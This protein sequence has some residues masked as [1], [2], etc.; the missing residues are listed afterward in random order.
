MTSAP[1]VAVIGGTGGIGS[2][3]VRRLLADGADVLA[4]G[5]DAGRLAELAALGAAVTTLDLA[6]PQAPGALAAAVAERFGGT[7]DALVAASGGH[8]PTGPTRSLDPAAVRRSLEENLLGVLGCV[9]AL[10]PALDRAATP[11]V[12]LLSGGG[13]TGPRPGYTAYALAKV[14]LVR[15]AENLA[16]EEPGW[17]VNAVAPGYVAT[18]IH[19]GTGE[20]AP[21]S[22]VEADVPAALIA[23]LIGPGSAGVTG[24]LISAPWDPWR[25]PSGLPLL[26]D[27]PS[28]GRL[29]RIDG[30]SFLD[31]GA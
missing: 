30:R 16:L 19:E 17:R 14:A 1:R 24:R 9:Q 31:A 27:H 20:P 6:D 15:L 12:V 23:W 2:A 25:D 10:A 21:A 28:F 7:L 5:R 3:V 18:R 29:R 13:A 4:T 11:S 22:A 26:R 8:G